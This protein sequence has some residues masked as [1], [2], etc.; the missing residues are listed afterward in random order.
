MKTD[1][2]GPLQTLEHRTCA[3]SCPFINWAH[4]EHPWPN[5]GQ[6]SH[7]VS[8]TFIDSIGQLKFMDQVVDRAHLMKDLVLARAHHDAGMLCAGPSQSCLNTY[9]AFLIWILCIAKEKLHVNLV[10]FFLH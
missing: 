10:V 6:S 4:H 3:K 9:L 8:I 5:L 2:I 1:C 7:E